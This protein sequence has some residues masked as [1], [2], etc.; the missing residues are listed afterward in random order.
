MAVT[1]PLRCR[2]AR[3]PVPRCKRRLR[4]SQSILT[5]FVANK[6]TAGGDL[7]AKA[8]RSRHRC[9]RDTREPK[10]ARKMATSTIPETAQ[11]V[12]ETAQSVPETAQSVPETAQSVRL[13]VPHVLRVPH[14]PRVLHAIHALHLAPPTARRLRIASSRRNP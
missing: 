7:L 13:H 14:V 1:L 11:S 4:A 12:P 8:E 9:G 2:R 10:L 3:T 5:N 6:H